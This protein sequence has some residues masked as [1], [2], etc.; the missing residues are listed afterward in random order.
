MLAVLETHSVQYHAPVYL[1]L[2]SQFG[3]PVTAIYGPDFS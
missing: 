3:I 1:A 2:G